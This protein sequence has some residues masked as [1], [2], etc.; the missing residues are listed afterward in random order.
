MFNTNRKNW[1]SLDDAFMFT[2]RV[3]FEKCFFEIKVWQLCVIAFRIEPGALLVDHYC[4][5]CH[6]WNLNTTAQL[7]WSIERAQWKLAQNGQL[8]K[9]MIYYIPNWLYQPFYFSNGHIS[10]T[11][12]ARLDPLAPN[13]PQRAGLSFPLS[14]KWPRPTLS[15]SFGL[16][17]E[18][19][20]FFGVFQVGQS[21]PL[22]PTT[23]PWDP[24]TSPKRFRKFA[25]SI[26]RL[27]DHFVNPP[28]QPLSVSF[29][30]TVQ[31]P[32]F[33]FQRF[34]R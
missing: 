21:G 6:I 4:Q 3:H 1:Q 22:W 10:G 27:P 8:T 32:S 13:R 33:G 16:F 12:R 28:F 24:M 34:Q 5:L 31:K 7:K 26:E 25:G 29:N 15:S 9:S 14:W 19:E 11:K 18:R 20:H 17:F 23:C 2:S 30:A